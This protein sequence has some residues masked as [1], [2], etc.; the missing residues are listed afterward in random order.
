MHKTLSHNCSANKDE[1]KQS[2]VSK[3]LS[4]NYSEE[5][6]KLCPKE[7]DK[8]EYTITEQIDEGNEVTYDVPNFNVS[9]VFECRRKIL[10]CHMKEHTW[11]LKAITLQE[12]FTICT[13]IRIVTAKYGPVKISKNLFS[14]SWKKKK[15]KSNVTSIILHAML[16]LSLP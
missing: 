1:S 4:Q 2:I 13:D 15:K 14:A 10:T 12:L 16:H 5:E 8:S 7:K 11:L 6:D 9:N 3:T